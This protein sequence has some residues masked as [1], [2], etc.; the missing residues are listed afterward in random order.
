VNNEAQRNYE[1]VVAPVDLSDGSANALRVGLSTGLI[2]A[3]GATVVHA[4]SAIAK[5][6]MFVAGSDKGAIARYIADERKKS[7]T[8]VMA[9]L[10]ANGFSG[11][12][13]GLEI[14]EGEAMEIISRTVSTLGADLLVMG[15]HGRSGLLKSLIG[16]VTERAL[17]SLSVDI[18]AVPPVRKRDA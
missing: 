17:R 13:L 18:L 16:S 14:H 8:E 6:K 2:S 15:T 1:R 12:R 3:K 7:L 11:E 10:T 4:F 5:G 9:F